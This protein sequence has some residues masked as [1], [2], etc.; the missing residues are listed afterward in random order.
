MQE[1][2]FEQVRERRTAVPLQAGVLVARA[3]R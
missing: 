2:G 1:A 3:A